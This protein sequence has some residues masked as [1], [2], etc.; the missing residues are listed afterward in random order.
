MVLGE[1][2]TN[3]FPHLEAQDG[4]SGFEDDSIYAF[5]GLPVERTFLPTLTFFLVIVWGW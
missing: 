3:L 1:L 2:S 5:P 4:S